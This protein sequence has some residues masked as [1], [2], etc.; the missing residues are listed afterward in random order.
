MKDHFPHNGINCDL[1][2][3]KNRTK[4]FHCL[5]R[6]YLDYELHKN[7][8]PNK[9]RNTRITLYCIF[10]FKT[11]KLKSRR[12]SIIKSVT[13]TL[14]DKVTKNIRLVTRHI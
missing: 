6:F 9:E 4:Y 8:I 2:T 14:D 5:F 3:Q 12:W 1:N 13:N 7:V 11:L 10:H